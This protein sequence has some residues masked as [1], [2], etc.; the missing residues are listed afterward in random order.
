M[1]KENTTM[2]R[3]ILLTAG[4]AV[5][6]ALVASAQPGRCGNKYRHDGL[7]MN[8]AKMCG[9]PG[10][11]A[12][13]GDRMADGPGLQQILEMADRLELTDAQR[14]KLKQMH[15]TFQLEQIDK[16]A[17]LKKA[18]VKLRGLM[19][20]DRASSTAVNKAIDDVSTLKAD[21]TKM[22]YRH[23]TEMRSVL[24][25][26]QQQMLK[27]LRVERRKE[28]RVRVFERDDD[29]PEEFEEEIPPDPGSGGR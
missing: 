13:R 9:G 22:R 17:N 20:D 25:D 26:K 27:E 6:V 23:R 5:A 7:G 29:D 14:E 28:V 11:A 3:L 4:F 12:G 21:I 2:K 10:I 24:T 16:H 8:C 1:K 19:R 18:E 15:E